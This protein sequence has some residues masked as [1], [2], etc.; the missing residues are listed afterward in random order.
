MQML[1]F[2]ILRRI[3][4][5]FTVL[6]I[7]RFTE[8][9][10]KRRSVEGIP[11]ALLFWVGI[12]VVGVFMYTCYIMYLV[13]L[14]LELLLF[15]L[16]LLIYNFIEYTGFAL[17]PT[18]SNKTVFCDI[19]LFLVKQ[20]KTSTFNFPPSSCLLSLLTLVGEDE[21]KSKGKSRNV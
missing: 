14:L 1:K 20:R 3:W 6:F 18:S 21:K 10:P 9:V 8:P 13:V 15:F 16:P 2:P 11:C 17:C 19:V 5:L 12:F 4:E 7:S